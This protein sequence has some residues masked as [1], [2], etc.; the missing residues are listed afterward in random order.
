MINPRISAVWS[1][2]SR[3]KIQVGHAS[4]Q[5]ESQRTRDVLLRLVITAAALN[6]ALAALL[7]LEHIVEREGVVERVAHRALHEAKHGE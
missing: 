5:H 3:E 2:V 7:K 4:Y 6:D 1:N